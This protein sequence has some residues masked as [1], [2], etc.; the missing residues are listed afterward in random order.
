MN[1]QLNIKQQGYYTI[2]TLVLLVIMTLAVI[3]LV[4]SSSTTTIISGNMAFKEAAIQYSDIMIRQ[5][6]N[7]INNLANPEV[8]IAIQYFATEQ[9]VDANGLPTTVNWNNVAIITQDQYRLQFITER[10]CTGSLP[11]A[12]TTTQCINFSRNSASSNNVGSQVFT[13][14]PV[15]YYRVTIR[16][17][18]PRNTLTFVQGIFTR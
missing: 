10:L 12:N 1:N 2:S 8:N 18:G 5:A 13:P 9:P 15:I 14:P 17:Q 7:Q 6:S 3:A 16:I 4:R 11:I